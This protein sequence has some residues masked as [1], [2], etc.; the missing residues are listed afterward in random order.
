MT[1]DA[2]VQ[3]GL[4]KKFDLFF[5]V[6]MK[7]LLSIGVTLVALMF[8]LPESWVAFGAKHVGTRLL[9]AGFTEIKVK[10]GS[11][12]GTW[13]PKAFVTNEANLQGANDGLQEVLNGLSDKPELKAK[14]LPVA[15]VISESSAHLQRQQEELTGEI[16]RASQA[17]PKSA[18]PVNGWLYA[19]LA[20][21]GNLIAPGRGIELG[22]ESSNPADI[23]SV[24]VTKD[25]PIVD[26]I[27]V[28][29][30]SSNESKS[31]TIE[32]AQLVK[33]GTQLSVEKT[34]PQKTIGSGLLIW[35]KV[36]VPPERVLQL[37]GK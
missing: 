20:T 26:N 6:L 15:N 8:V 11:I 32:H 33:S 27:E 31:S 21:N 13:N 24:T 19:G 12:E 2:T 14:L 25:S 17:L 5:A 30:L 7:A 1:T 37:A 9:A 23:K 36:T 16:A 3:D 4:L 28:E 29:G 22:K 18:S 35:V 34:V 10:P